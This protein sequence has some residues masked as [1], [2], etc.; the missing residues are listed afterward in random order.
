MSGKDSTMP[1]DICLAPAP[2]SARMFRLVVALGLIALLLG[3]IAAT[4]APPPRN[5]DT[6][7]PGAYEAWHGNVRRSR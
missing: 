1:K 4:D 5:T 2:R 7:A 6:A 3:L